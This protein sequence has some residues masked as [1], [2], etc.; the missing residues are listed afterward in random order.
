MHAPYKASELQALF[1]KEYEYLQDMIS[2]M[3]ASMWNVHRVFHKDPYHESAKIM[4]A[5]IRHCLQ[6]VTL[7]IFSDSDKI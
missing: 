3:K 1:S 6:S 2:N 5:K 7:Q 4:Q